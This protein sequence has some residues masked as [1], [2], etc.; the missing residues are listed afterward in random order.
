MSVIAAPRIENPMHPGE[1][2]DELYLAPLDMSA[3]KLARA[4]HVPRTRIE[5]L[6]A[7][8]TRLTPDTAH[9]LARFFRTTPQL[10]LAMQASWDAV[11][12]A[13]DIDALEAIEPLEAA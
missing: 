5:R 12:G 6:V 1:V 10:W 3:G 9:R 7:G 4:L 8:Q 2:L 11:H 13:T